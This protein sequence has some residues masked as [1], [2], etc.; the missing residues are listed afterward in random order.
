METNNLYIWSIKNIKSNRISIHAAQV[1]FFIMVSFFSSISLFRS[2][3]SLSPFPFSL[4][5]AFRL[6]LI[7]HFPLKCFFLFLPHSI[8]S[9]S[10]SPSLFL[11]PPFPPDFIF[12]QSLFLSPPTSFR[13]PVPK[14][15]LSFRFNFLPVYWNKKR[16]HVY[17]NSDSI[18][19]LLGKDFASV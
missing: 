18:R 3:E 15:P 1:A 9:V 17:R 8:S 14:S 6:F 2:S 10:V 7:F 19:F 4:F 11:L 13:F 16:T 12:Y 5:P